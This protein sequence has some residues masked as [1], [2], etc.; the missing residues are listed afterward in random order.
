MFVRVDGVVGT[1]GGV[2]GRGAADAAPGGRG[3]AAAGPEAEAGLGRPG[4]ARRVSMTVTGPAVTL[5]RDDDKV[6]E[7]YRTWR[8]LSRWCSCRCT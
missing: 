6:L 1:F 4:S 8:M 2:V 5:Q 3:A 7:P